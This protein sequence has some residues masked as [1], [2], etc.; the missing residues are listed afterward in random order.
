[1]KK[2][3]NKHDK[4]K[5][6]KTVL[7]RRK[8]W[9]NGEKKI[10]IKENIRRKNMWMKAKKKKEGDEKKRK[11]VMM[12][13]NLIRGGLRKEDGDDERENEEIGTRRRG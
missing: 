13:E 9:K 11:K 12:K 6:E 5:R 3:G 8:K 4:M 7:G 1:M 10:Q 2:K